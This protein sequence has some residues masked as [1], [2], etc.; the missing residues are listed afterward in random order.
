MRKIIFFI[1]VLL[2]S[3]F[4][5]NAQWIVLN[6]GTAEDLK[7][8]FF[9]DENNGWIVGKEG[10][11]KRTIN[12][13]VTWISQASGTSETLESVFFSNGN[14]GWAVGKK[15]TILYTVNAGGTWTAQVSGTT[16][17]LTAVHFWGA[18]GVVV[19][20]DG[21]V[22]TS[23]N[24]G[25]TWISRS[26]GVSKTLNAVQFTDASTVYA[27][28]KDGVFI[29]S[30]NAGMNW[31]SQSIPSMNDDIEDLHFPS[32]GKGYICAEEGGVITT[33]G[34]GTFNSINV[35]TS[36]DLKSVF[37]V[38]NQRGWAVGEEGR[39]FCTV[40][41]GTSWIF[42]I[43]SNMGETLESV[44]FPSE[45]VG[46]CVGEDGVLLKL[47][48]AN[49]VSIEEAEKTAYTFFPNPA[50]DYINLVISDASLNQQQATVFIYTTEGRCAREITMMLSE[51]NTIDLSGLSA[52]NY[53][54]V[55]IAGDFS[56]TGN[57]IK[58]E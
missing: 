52:G 14:I 56:L 40:N 34:T 7:D 31:V 5:L 17:E 44:H 19:G 16:K 53:I 28:G 39:I 49:T 27:G 55:C 22:L 35:S 48:G 51:T 38:N 47:T 8:V 1:P 4:G 9:T 24:Y 15:G 11:I 46:Y 45:F 54:I 30:A 42:Q 29:K 10:I 18:N 32:G 13:G 50:R 2:L 26:A 43:M 12:G 58:Y 6:S 3:V 21:L 37:F 23:G 57:I 41:G 20:K 25:Q 36:R 33:N